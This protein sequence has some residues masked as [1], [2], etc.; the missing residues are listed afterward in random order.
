MGA[1]ICVSTLAFVFAN[2]AGP[3]DFEQ[4]WFGAG[5]MLHGS[6]PYAAIGPGRERDQQWPL[7]Y[8]GPALVIA[9]PLHALS[10]RAARVVFSVLGAAALTFAMTRDGFERLRLF[11]SYSFLSAVSLAQWTPVLAL[12]VL[13]P[14]VGFFAAAKPN[15][16]VAALA[17][18]RDRRALAR[19]IIGC[20]AV[21][22]VSIIALPS[23]PA[24]WLDATRHAPANV[25]L[26]TFL[27]LGPLV[28]LVAF[29]WR[30]P[31]ARMLGALALVPQNPVPHSAVLMFAAPWHWWE[32]S[33]LAALSWAVVPIV[34]RSGIDTTTYAGFA[35]A[36]GHATV[37]FVY[38]PMVVA[39]L[40]RP[41]RSELGQVP[42]RPRPPLDAELPS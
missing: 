8:P 38:L 12:S 33:A 4:V 5:K 1:V 18:A 25:P 31:E 10:A 27:P 41:N 6:D 7:L 20:I 15:V 35:R 34:Y 19:M 17:G 11:A 21:T 24:S 42:F 14:S 9:A 39:V 26:V 13:V 28:L 32:A 23:W 37:A 36:M 40:R 29:R 22:V 16:G 3:Q 2:H 30:R